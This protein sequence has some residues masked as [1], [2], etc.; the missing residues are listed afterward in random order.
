LRAQPGA[1]EQL[2]S[3]RRSGSKEPSVPCGQSSGK[4]ELDR[5]GDSGGPA[6]SWP[7]QKDRSC[8]AGPRREVRPSVRRR[9]RVRNTCD[10]DH[11]PRACVGRDWRAKTERPK[12]G[13]LF[14]A[15]APASPAER[16]QKVGVNTQTQPQ[17]SQGGFPYRHK[18]QTL[19]TLSG[20]RYRG[21]LIPKNLIILC[22]VRSCVPLWG[23][24]AFFST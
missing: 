24:G 18:A 10:G 20:R 14:W 9:A 8:S 3:G 21:S 11:D 16:F 22:C 1:S 17:L 2:G 15:P 4:Q 23:W 5:T 13:L 19:T 7:P 6:T 12:K